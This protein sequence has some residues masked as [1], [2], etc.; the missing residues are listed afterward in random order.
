MKHQINIDI[1]AR[2]QKCLG[3]REKI[4]KKSKTMEYQV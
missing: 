3:I 1:K 4:Q 2:I